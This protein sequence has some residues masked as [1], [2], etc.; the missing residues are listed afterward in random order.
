MKESTKIRR[1]ISKYLKNNCP[2]F[3]DILEKHFHGRDLIFKRFNAKA[4]TIKCTKEVALELCTEITFLT[5]NHYAEDRDFDNF[6]CDCYE[7]LR[8]ENFEESTM[9]KLLRDIWENIFVGKNIK[10]AKI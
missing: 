2:E 1:K 5:L 7:V 10:N 8:N 6:Y 3:V 9:E 4:V